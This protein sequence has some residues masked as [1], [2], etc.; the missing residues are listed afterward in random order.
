MSDLKP[1]PFCNGQANIS[2]NAKR[3]DAYGRNIEGTAIAC[4]NCGATI[5]F[6]S[7]H[8]AIEAW[9]RR[10]DDDKQRSG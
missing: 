6:R 2:Y 9:N 8:I 7:R 5:F 1:C 3:K 4:E 10:V